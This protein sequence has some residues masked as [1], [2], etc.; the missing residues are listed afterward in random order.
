VFCGKAIIATDKVA[1]PRVPLS[2]AV[3]IGNILFVSGRTPINVIMK[4]PE[5]IYRAKCIK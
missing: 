5:A 2:A 3:E 1:K 4:S